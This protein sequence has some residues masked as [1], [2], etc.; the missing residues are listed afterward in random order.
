MQMASLRLVILFRD[1]GSS[2]GPDAFVAALSQRGLTARCVPVLETHLDVT[3]L[4]SALLAPDLT[5]DALAVTS[6]RA[7]DALREAATLLPPA[8]MERLLVPTFVVGQRTATA[9]R[10]ALPALRAELVLGADAGSAEK[11]APIVQLEL[12]RLATRAAGEEE[13][14]L[15]VLF[16][17]GD[18]RLDTLPA[19]LRAGGMRVLE[20]TT[21]STAPAAPDRIAS[22]AD[23]SRAAACVFF[24]PSGCQA[25]LASPELAALLA[26]RPSRFSVCSSAAAGG[27]VTTSACVASGASVPCVALG[28]TTAQ[29]LVRLGVP[30]ARVSASPSPVSLAEAV[31]S[32]L[33]EEAQLQCRSVAADGAGASGSHDELN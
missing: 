25:V 21:Y 9:V 19:Q 2:E 16:L 23:M 24:S 4:A 22:A 27:G 32:A 33:P 30:V 15:T 6:H 10:A 1:P 29:A 3:A 14:P 17:C 26:P 7:C 28:P 18:R 20:V 8:L 5:L 31:V 11:L 12:P 13:R